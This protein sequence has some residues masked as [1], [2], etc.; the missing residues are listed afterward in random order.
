M[1][2]L[3]YR[4]VFISDLHL[5]TANA[6]AEYLLDF[7]QHVRCDYLFLNGDIFDI[8]K[9]RTRRWHWPLIKTRLL[10]RIMEMAGSGVQV[11]YVPGNHDAFFRD[12]LGCE[13]AGVQVCRQY[14]HRL[15]NGGRALVL[16]GDEFDGLVRHNRLLKLLGNMGYEALMWLNRINHHWRRRSGRCYWSL[17]RAIKQQVPNARSYIE[18]Y[19]QAALKHARER[20]FDTIICG[21][22][23]QACLRK[24]NGVTYANSGDWVEHCTA[25]VEHIDGRLELLDWVNQSQ[26]LLDATKLLDQN[27]DRQA[28]AI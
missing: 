15:A 19:E 22:I 24:E 27:R 13:I 11:V 5:G 18:K 14:E 2:T 21:H 9:M 12:Y 23:H 3:S 25:L 26:Q 28:A 4:S 17:S 7:L 8:W 20:G 16:H 10:Q 6:Q 1:Q